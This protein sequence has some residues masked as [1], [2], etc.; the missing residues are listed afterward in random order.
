MPTATDKD[1]LMHLEQRLR[2]AIQ[3]ARAV[4]LAVQDAQELLTALKAVKER[5][6][7]KDDD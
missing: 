4:E 6:E 1:L 5:R 2:H 3:Y 7:A